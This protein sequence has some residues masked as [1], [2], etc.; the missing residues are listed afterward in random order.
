MRQP[1]RMAKDL[2]DG[3]RW[4]CIWQC[5][6]SYRATSSRSIQRHLDVCCMRMEESANEVKAQVVQ[7][8]RG[9]GRKKREHAAQH[10]DNHKTEG[11]ESTIQDALIDPHTVATQHFSSYSFRS[12]ADDL[13]LAAAAPPSLTIIQPPMDENVSRQRLGHVDYHDRCGVSPGLV[14]LTVSLL[15]PP[16][17]LTSSATCLPTDPSAALLHQPE[18]SSNVL[19][20][21][22]PTIELLDDTPAAT[23]VETNS[24][25]LLGLAPAPG[26]EPSVASLLSPSSVHNTA[27]ARL[28]TDLVSDHLRSFLVSLYLRCGTRHP[29]FEQDVVSPVIVVEAILAA[30]TI[31]SQANAGCT[32]TEANTWNGHQT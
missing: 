6:K 22:H 20:L 5:G 17:P 19:P 30:R 25:P 28:I 12:D 24:P 13:M 21:L 2:S 1:R 15:P 16:L 32:I 14:P 27:I 31:Q 18:S 9:T 7:V 29:V 10:K 8:R 11:S 23:V 26:A 3:E 4:D